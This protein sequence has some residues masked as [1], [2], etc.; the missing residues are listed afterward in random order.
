ME[1]WLLYFEAIWGKHCMR[2]V[3]LEI[4]YNISQRSLRRVFDNKLEKHIKCV[5][6]WPK[7]VSYLEDNIL[8]KSKWENITTV[9]V[10]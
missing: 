7:F 8:R 6:T 1:E 5:Y 4:R 3:D 2:W 9:V 10:S